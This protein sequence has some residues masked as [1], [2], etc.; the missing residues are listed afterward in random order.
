[1]LQKFAH[2]FR[3][4]TDREGAQFSQGLL[5][6]KL[7][8][9]G[10]LRRNRGPHR[11]IARRLR[12]R[13]QRTVLRSRAGKVAGASARLKA[14]QDCALPGWRAVVCRRAVPDSADLTS[15]GFSGRSGFLIVQFAGFPSDRTSG[16]RAS[17]FRLKPRNALP[18]SRFGYGSRSWKLQ[19]LRSDKLA[20]ESEVQRLASDA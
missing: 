13:S 5:G 9:V 16:F 19:H 20:F 8:N 2:N 10:C 1:M 14:D 4:R 15:S 3:A 11:S 12:G 18:L 6:A 17:D 7:G